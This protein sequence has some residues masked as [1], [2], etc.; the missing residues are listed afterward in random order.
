MWDL[1]V[2]FPSLALF[3]FTINVFTSSDDVLPSFVNICQVIQS[4]RSNNIYI[5]KITKRRISIKM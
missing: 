1:I 5:R 3:Y 4:Y 2:L